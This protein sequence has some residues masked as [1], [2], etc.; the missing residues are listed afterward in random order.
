[1]VS[2]ISSLNSR[3]FPRLKIGIGSVKKDEVVNY[4]LGKFSKNE[5]NIIEDE[6]NNFN[7][8]IDSF[9]NHGIDKTMNCYNSKR[10]E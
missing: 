9:I 6:Y 8:I 7:D 1:M 4:V 5:L 3:D 10:N 2:I